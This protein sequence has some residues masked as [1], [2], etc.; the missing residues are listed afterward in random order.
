[1][2]THEKFAEERTSIEPRLEAYIAT[3]RAQNNGS[4]A[5]TTQIRRLQESLYQLQND[6]LQAAD[7]SDKLRR[8]VADLT[9]ANADIQLE[10]TSA[11]E[12]QQKVEAAAEIASVIERVIGLALA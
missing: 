5:M 9:A 6:E 2:A 3:L 7:N 10:I 12:F 1:M 4:E 8:A 11:K